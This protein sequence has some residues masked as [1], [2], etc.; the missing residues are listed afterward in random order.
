MK[1]ANKRSLKTRKG[2]DEEGNMVINRQRNTIIKA[3]KD[4]HFKYNLSYKPVNRGN[5]EKQYIKTL[6]YLG[7]TYYINLNTFFL[8]YIRLVL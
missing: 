2:K 7:Y 5:S 8:R 3:K 1:T 6:K 4:Y